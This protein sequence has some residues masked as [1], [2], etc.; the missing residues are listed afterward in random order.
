MMNRLSSTH[1]LRPIDWCYQFARM[2]LSSDLRSEEG[3]DHSSIIE[4]HEFLN[5]LYM[6]GTDTGA[7]SATVMHEYPLQW[8]A[9][10]IY[11][12]RNGIMPAMIEARFLAGESAEDIA[13]NV[14]VCAE[15]ITLY[16]QN[17]FDVA[18]RLE[19][20]D[21]IRS[22]VLSS[23]TAMKGND[24]ELL[25]QIGY[26]AG[27][28]ALNMVLGTT[29]KDSTRQ[30]PQAALAVC[31]DAQLLVQAFA[32]AHGV[33]PADQQSIRSILQSYARSRAAAQDDGT[34]TPL[35]QGIEAMLDDVPWTMGRKGVDPEQMKWHTSAVELRADDMQKVGMGTTLEN[36]E[37][38]LAIQP[39]GNREPEQL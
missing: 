37:E 17:Y 11:A 16:E 18:D 1:P 29:P 32:A 20:A 14:G 15:V 34:L 9:F 6:S 31:I 26:T 27:A 3:V 13:H 2:L 10:D 4:L 39:P 8:L 24:N 19:Y 36:E 21:F 33:N 7:D 38:L 35:M 12:D 30:D 23:G 5:A 25:R 28:K 22:E